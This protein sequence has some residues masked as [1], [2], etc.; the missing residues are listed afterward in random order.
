[1][2]LPAAAPHVMCQAKFK[3]TG[4]V[5]IA[6]MGVASPEGAEVAATLLMGNVG[7]LKKVWAK[8]GCGRGCLAWLGAHAGGSKPATPCQ[9]CA[10][11]RRAARSASPPHP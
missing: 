1:M 7:L 5:A 2:P 11:A 10:G 9:L 6:A 3:K 4:S 8:V